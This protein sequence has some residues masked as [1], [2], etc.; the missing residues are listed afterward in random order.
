MTKAKAALVGADGLKARLKATAEQLPEPSRVR[1]H[2]A[3]SWLNRAEAE[4]TD[5]DA[6]FIFLWVAFNAAYA[7]EFGFEKTER[8][9]LRGFLDKLQSV[10]GEGT[11][12]QL[13]FDKFSG[14]VRMLIENKYVFE[15]FWRALRDHDRSERW[16]ERFEKENKSAFKAVMGKDTVAVLGVVFDRLYVLR[17]QLVHGG[18]TWN[19]KVN[20]QQVRDGAAMLHLL[21]PAMIGLMLDHP[22]L[23]LGAISFPVI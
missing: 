18:A 20:R 21:L 23:E 10:D 12:H 5:H 14:P 8:D 13:V 7:Q 4:S 22:G 3:I 11:L 16:K 19:S 9:Q 15:P 6:R 1:I 2:R 17:N